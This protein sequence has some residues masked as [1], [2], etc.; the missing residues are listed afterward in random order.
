MK[1]TLLLLLF[2][3]S[4]SPRKE[5]DTNDTDFRRINY[6]V[7]NNYLDSVGKKIVPNDSFQY[8]AYSTYYQGYG[9]GKTS[10]TLLKEGGDASLKKTIAKPFQP[11]GIF[12][13]GHP[14]YRCNYVTIIEN[15]E[16]RYIRTE[17]EF[18]NFI[19]N[20]DNLEEALLLAHTY[21]YQLDDDKRA[22]LYK[23]I[24]NGYQLRLMKYHELPL[25]KEL[26]DIKIHEDGFMKT[27]SLGIYNEGLDVLN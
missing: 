6:S 9:D 7:T 22:S 2:L 11:Y 27:Q 5:G 25:S 19:G 12:E 23:R 8:W 4:C 3:V 26:I 21:G 1:V 24:E 20:I 14:S 13:G 15:G 17:E 10:I 16:L 18:R